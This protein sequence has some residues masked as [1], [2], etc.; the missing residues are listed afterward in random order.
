MLL[1]TNANENLRLLYRYC[2]DFAI[3][4]IHLTG[5][6]I[7]INKNLHKNNVFIANKKK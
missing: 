5:V 6:L 7:R 3:N 4:D 2:F 1:I